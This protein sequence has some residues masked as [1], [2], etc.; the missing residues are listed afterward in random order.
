M[1]GVTETLHDYGALAFWDFATAAPYVDINMNPV[2]PGEKKPG[3]LWKDAIYFSGHKFI[4]G[5][6]T[7]GWFGRAE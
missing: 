2:S 7:P 1:D 5:P 3:A 4:G 6:D